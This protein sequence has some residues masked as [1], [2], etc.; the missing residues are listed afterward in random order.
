MGLCAALVEVPRH[1]VVTGSAELDVH[2]VA[3]AVSFWWYSAR[4]SS[5]LS[6]VAFKGMAPA[7]RK[8]CH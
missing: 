7:D 3:Q 5:G 2:G 6:W 8:S 4:P 1:T